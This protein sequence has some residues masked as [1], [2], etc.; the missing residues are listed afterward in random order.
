VHLQDPEAAGDPVRPAEGLLL[1]RERK[2][3][4]H[5]RVSLHGEYN[6]DKPDL[7]IAL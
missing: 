3:G 2:R 4:R 1:H 5:A 7:L 6:N